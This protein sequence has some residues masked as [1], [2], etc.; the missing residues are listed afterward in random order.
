MRIILNK[1]SLDLFRKNI[2]IN[3]KVSYLAKICD[4]SINT[5]KYWLFNTGSFPSKKFEQLF[6][7]S[8][9]LE[10]QLIFKKVSDYWYISKASKLGGLARNKKY[11]NFGTKEGR[12]L[13]GLKSIKTHKSRPSA[14][15]NTKEIIKPIKGIELAELIGIMIGD[16]HLS[17][18]QASFTTNSD[19]DYE[20]ALYV[21]YLF[22]KL[23]SIKGTIR[24]RKNKKAVDITVSSVNIV[25]YINKLGMP[26]GN[27]LQKGLKFPLWIKRDILYSKAF[28]RGL[29][30]TD[31]CIYIDKHK[32]K[33]KIYSH[34][35]W[36]FTSYDDKFLKEVKFSLEKLNFKP[37][38]T[39][40]QKSIYL[41]RKNDI[42]RY[43]EFIG[44]NNL[45]HKN[46]FLK[47]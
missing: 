12:R 35:G 21:N 33:N 7:L 32:Y 18:Y 10:N 34:L 39:I 30:D 26:I 37:T 17:K 28:I 22:K 15:K 8:N 19:T 3:N 41:R 11:G 14:F 42:I 47:L 5:I 25:K 9:T 36:T 38:G 24:K 29:F 4:V 20:H 44:T 31:G 45:K 2:L 46:R 1:K 16:G 13:G 27:K 23:F 6:K 40:K 43:F